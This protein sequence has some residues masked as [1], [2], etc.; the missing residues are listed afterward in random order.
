MSELYAVVGTYVTGAWVAAAI[1]AARWALHQRTSIAAFL[2]LSGWVGV[3]LI[4]VLILMA[5]A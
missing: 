3:V 4:C 5:A 1:V 2:R